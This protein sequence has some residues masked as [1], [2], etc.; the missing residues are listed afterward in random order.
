M[1]AMEDVLDL[2]EEDYDP[3]YP[4]VC[5]DEKLV[6]RHFVNTHVKR[7]VGGDE[8]LDRSFAHGAPARGEHE[9]VIEHAARAIR[10]S[11]LDPSKY[12]AETNMAQGLFLLGRYDE[13]V[14]WSAKALAQQPNYILALRT[15]AAANALG[16]NIDEARKAIADLRRISPTLSISGLK[17]L[18]PYRRSQD[19]ERIAEGLR[20]AGLPE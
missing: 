3:R 20:L 18:F 15:S 2:Y 12:R 19:I 17:G 8:F 5:F 11:P 10:L 14:S 4:S 13:A 7:H 6:A 9:T 1:A 16:G